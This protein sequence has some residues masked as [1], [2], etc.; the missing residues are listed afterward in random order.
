LRATCIVS[1]HKHPNQIPRPRPTPA[2]S[3][4]WRTWHNH[5]ITFPNRH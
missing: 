3:G 1:V 5:C 4:V 2:N